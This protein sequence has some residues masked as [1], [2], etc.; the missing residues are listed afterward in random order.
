M[1]TRRVLA[2][3]LVAAAVAFAVPGGVA[4]AKEFTPRC[5]VATAIGERPHELAFRARC[6]FEMDSVSVEPA[7][8]AIVR[9]VRH[10]P[11]LTNPDP[12]DHFRCWRKHNSARCAGKAGDGVTM[13]GALRMHGARCATATRFYVQGGVDCDPP[14][15]NCIAIGYFAEERDPKPSGCG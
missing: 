8:P 5:H 11:H 13:A 4:P 6:N 14:A 12:E 7:D 1:R 10:H 3:A 2:A 15:E 9:A